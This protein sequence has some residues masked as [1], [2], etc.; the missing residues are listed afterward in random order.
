MWDRLLQDAHA[1]LS[2]QQDRL[3]RDFDLNG[4][5]KYHYDQ[6][7]GLIKFST[8][9]EVGFV[10]DIQVVGSTSTKSG[11]WLW[12]WDNPSIE[13]RV[14]TLSLEVKKYGQVNGFKRLV[15]PKW[16][17]DENDGWEMTV[18]AAFLSQADGGYRFPGENGAL[19][20]VLQNARL[21]PPG[22]LSASETPPQV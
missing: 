8:N 10:A 12:S 11:T 15:E 3:R 2:I 5:K 22:S 4:W 13:P 1:Y 7:T 17:G 16:I 21:V 18:V 14:Q 19:F 20:L 9:G 6:E